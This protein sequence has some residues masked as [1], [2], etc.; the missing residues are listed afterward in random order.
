MAIPIERISS[1]SLLRSN[2]S[3]D[4][5]K[6]IVAAINGADA[7]E[8]VKSN[9]T[10]HDN[11]LHTRD[12]D[13]DL[14]KFNQIFV[15]G[16][17]KASIPM[18]GA[19]SEILQDRITKGVVIT[20]EGYL[21]PGNYRIPPQVRVIEAGHPIPDQRNLY[22]GEQIIEL[23]SEMTSN[24]LMICLISGGGSSLLMH[25]F[26]GISL[27]DI[28]ITTRKLLHCGASI[29]EMNT[30][31]KHVDL[32]KGGGLLK[33]FS[34]ATVMTLLLSDVMGDDLEVIASGP[35]VA[36]STTFSDGWAIFDRYQIVDQVPGRILSIIAA[37]I[38]GKIP[39]TIKSGDPI[40]F[41]VSN[42]IIGNNSDAISSSIQIAKT[43]GFDARI[44]PYPLLGE[45]SV[46][47]DVLAFEAKSFQVQSSPRRTPTCM[48]AGGETIV[49]V[50]DPGKGGRNQELALGA[51]KGVSE[52]KDVILVSLATDGGDGPTDAAGAV[53]TPETYTRGLAK[54]LDAEEYLNGNNS[55]NYF[56]PLEDLIK[57]G[58]TL[59]NVNDL[60]FI[61]IL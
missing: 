53:V 6:I 38:Q 4:I 48:V 18:V 41:N 30:I 58:P 35:T 43:C 32:F 36:D 42:I 25:L 17:G 27:Q 23:T 54:G 8:K 56:E 47:G 12:I 44:L 26:P 3:D 52:L 11:Y 60:G 14:S 33:F 39:E 29:N 59:T 55:Y 46:M 24:D 34:H 22:A 2:R 20:K 57:T 28:Q 9:V 45:A 10:C 51:V 40:L 49:T 21:A 5:R 7:G 15:I 61:F 16:A 31:R 13:Y 37:G 50:K 19:I 1:Y